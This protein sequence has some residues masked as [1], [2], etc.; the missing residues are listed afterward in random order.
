MWSVTGSFV[1]RFRLLGWYW[2]STPPEAL[3]SADGRADGDNRGWV[4][5]GRVL[6]EALVR[7]VGTEVAFVLGERGAGVSFVVGQPR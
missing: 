5:T 7:A 1:D 6:L 2:L 4:V 3:F